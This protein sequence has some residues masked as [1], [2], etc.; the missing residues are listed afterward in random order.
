MRL[1]AAIEYTHTTGE[2][3]LI[4]NIG[5]IGGRR[6]DFGIVLPVTDVEIFPRVLARDAGDCEIDPFLLI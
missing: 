5:N 3:R 6:I 4:Q 2:R 1:A